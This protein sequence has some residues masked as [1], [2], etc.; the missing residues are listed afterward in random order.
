MRTFL[1]AL[2]LAFAPAAYSQPVLA[3][4]DSLL[5]DGQYD[6]ALADVEKSLL[7]EKDAAIAQRI[8]LKKVEVLV[9]QRN[10]AQA[11]ALINEIEK[12]H[13]TGLPLAELKRVEGTLLQYQ[14]KNEW[15]EKMLLEAEQLLTAI[16]KQQSLEMAN[17]LTALGLVHYNSGNRAQAEEQLTMALSIRQKILPEAHERIA[18]S[19]NDLGLV[20]SRSNPDKALTYY[21][22]ALPIYQKLHGETH[23]KIAINNTN[24]AVIYQNLELYGDAINNLKTSLATWEKISAQPNPQKAFVLFQ[25]GYTYQKMQNNAN[26][27]TYYNRSL[28]EYKKSYGNTHPDVAGVLNA[29]GNLAKSSNEYTKALQFYH[30]ALQANI[31]NFTNADVLSIPS[32]REYYNGNYFLYSL[33]YKAQVLEA[34]HFG[35]TLRFS[36]LRASFA[37]LIVCDS[38]ID[39]L[40]QQ[41]NN[42]AD[43][44]ALGAIANEVYAD[45]VRVATHMSGIASAHRNY[46]REQAFYFA[47]KSKSAVLLEAINEANAKSF[48]GIPETLLL[49]EQ[50]LKS[51]IAVCAQK[52][53]QKPTEQEETILREALFNVNKEYQNFTRELEHQ[54]PEYYNLKFNTATPS[55]T[56]LQK[57]LNMSTALLSYFIDDSKA[58]TTPTLYIFLIT[59]KKLTI[60]Q[61]ALPPE[62][63][64]YLTG[65]RNG[66]Y[67][68]VDKILQ[69]TGHHLYKLLLPAIPS[70]VKSLVVFPTGRL[71]VIPFEAF[72]VKEARGNQAPRYLLNK[73]DIR[74]EFSASLALQKKVIDKRATSILLCAPVT[75]EEKDNLNDLP[76]TEREVKSISQLFTTHQ[77]D[78]RILLRT[79]AS[80]SAIKGNA[81]SE[82]DVL[83][84]A[85]HGV[86][87][88]QQPELSRIFLQHTQTDDGYLYSGEIYNLKLKANLVTLSACQ[89][90]LGK[91]SKGEGVIGLSRALAYAGATNIMVSFWSVADESTAQLMT[92]FYEDSLKGNGS[93]STSL[94]QVKKQMLHHPVYRAPYYWA[95]FVLIGF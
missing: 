71:G 60:S 61:R 79:D 58:N 94:Q 2:F 8:L 44:I 22:K 76:G 32:T 10:Y 52:L 95:A 40:R 21:E 77:A 75:F 34:R 85:T 24:T 48:A 33:M 28:E 93:F 41:S 45:G 55:I 25:L 42:E 3:V 6:K 11:T 57:K 20:Y 39:K 18:G 67:Y 15:A 5:L 49:K 66:I 30:T 26:A 9:L 91:I 53:S 27:E 4:A 12:Q 70:S 35:K 87:D 46:Y 23:A 47:E 14:G 86:V 89:T 59:H 17:V 84:F 81:L 16:G 56:A 1:L 19:Y 88:E 43:K 72:V 90:G 83:H 69:S 37:N 73:Y 80:E 78:S 54:F 50:E 63:D 51:S 38:L 82:F 62:F 36:D 65:F 68:Q 92:N 31:N 7:E 64:K 13:P 29:L 74:Y